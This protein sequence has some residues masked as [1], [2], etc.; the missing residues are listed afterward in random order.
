METTEM[1]DLVKRN[2]EEL[3]RITV[4]PYELG[5][6]HELELEN[7]RLIRSY[8]EVK[9]INKQ[10]LD[11]LN[12]AKGLQRA[13][14]PKEKHLLNIFDEAF[15]YYQPRD[16]V[17]GDFYWFTKVND[18]VIVVVADCTGHGVPAAFMSI[19]GNSLLSQIIH[20]ENNLNPAL[21]LQR[22]DYKI[23]KAFAQGDI[24]DDIIN[25][26]MDMGACLIDYESF[27]I[28]Y[29]GAKRPLFVCRKEE[30]LVFQGN[31]FMVGGFWGEEKRFENIEIPFQEGDNIYMFTDGYTDQFGGP[32]GKKLMTTTFKEYL[33]EIQSLP[34]IEKRAVIVRKF[35]SWKGE[36]PQIDDVLVVGIT[37]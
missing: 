25:D 12:Y 4:L 34:M 21:I 30:V 17:S 16:I 31:K 3:S 36:Q 22:L 1:L 13:L 37:L 35:E 5:G 9:T 20:E 15:I 10:V 14:L 18:K 28:S 23:K 24:D 27:K 6:K 2:R 29:S 7:S 33:S 26:G 8:N 11:S 19:L 32:S